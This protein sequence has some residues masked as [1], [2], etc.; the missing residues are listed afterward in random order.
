MCV[1]VFKL[2]LTLPQ[3]LCLQVKE[4]TIEHILEYT[5]QQR[6]KPP[7]MLSILDAMIMIEELNLPLKRNQAFIMKYL[8]KHREALFVVRLARL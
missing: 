1:C 7:A 5:A 3:E 6:H 4:S 2:P 8:P